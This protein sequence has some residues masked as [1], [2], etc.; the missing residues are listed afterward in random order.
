M[1]ESLIKRLIASIRCGSCGQTYEE[2]HI[3]I[4]EH[5]D[6]LWFLKVSCSS[7]HMRCL[8]AA[9]IREDARPEFITDLTRAELKKFRGRDSISEDDL[10]DMHDFLKNFDGD[11]SRLFPKE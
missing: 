3:E 11:L 7:C 8:V 6:E 1:E 4:I 5:Q 9:I 10:L 2:D